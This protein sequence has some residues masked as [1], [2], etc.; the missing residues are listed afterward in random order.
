M[1]IR[2]PHFLSTFDRSKQ[3]CRLFSYYLGLTSRATTNLTAH[4]R[5]LHVTS[6]RAICRGGATIEFMGPW[7]PNIFLEA[8]HLHDEFPIDI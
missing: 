6:R 5:S 1:T 3:N 7:S 8:L 2:K 4:G